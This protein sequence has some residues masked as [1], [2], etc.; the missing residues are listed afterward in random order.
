M[1]RGLYTSAWSMLA[2]QKKLDV[3]TNNMANVNTSAYKKDT[4]VYQSFPEI[5]TRRINDTQSPTNPSAVV[6]TMELSSDVGEV[7]TYYTQGQMVQTGDRYD[8]AIKDDNTGEAASPAFF[9]VGVTNPQD[10]TIQE[11]YTK[12]GSFCLDANNQLVTGDGYAVLGKKGPITLKQGDFTVDEKGNIIQNGAVVDTLRIAQFA[13][14]TQLRKFGNNLVQNNGG[15]V[16]EFTGSVI[17][18][19]DEQSNVNVIDEMVDMITV[20]RAYEANQKVLQAQDGTLE[21][22]VN[23][24]GLVR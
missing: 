24:V 7:Y 11:F 21:K 10:N 23:E 1:I 15:E 22:A 20:M 3:I 4:V 17:Q 14:S 13:D 9:T 16:A 6:G 12:N 19:Y 18:G 2:N 5:L 8:L